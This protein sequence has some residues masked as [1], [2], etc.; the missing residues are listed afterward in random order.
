MTEVLQVFD[1]AKV[2]DSHNSHYEDHLLERFLD[3]TALV[4]GDNENLLGEIDPEGKYFR[5]G[6]IGAVYC[7]IRDRIVGVFG[8]NSP[9]L[10]RMLDI[11]SA[12]CE[13]YRTRF[14]I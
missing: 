13:D 1:L 9:E 12:A 14:E 4:S 6:E 7:I 5:E 8:A 2:I 3:G 11:L 10:D